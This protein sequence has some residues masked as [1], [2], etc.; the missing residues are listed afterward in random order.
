MSFE[1]DLESFTSKVERL[2]K[3]AFVDATVEVRRSIVEGSTLTGAPGQPV[4]TGALKASF[5]DNFTGPTSWQIT[6]NMEYAP[7]IEDGVGRF[8]PITLR[9]SVGGFHS[10][11]L[12]VAGWQ[13]IVDHVSRGNVTP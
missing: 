6:T 5:V 11:A 7:P 13:R 3:D 12:T 10:V 1:R 4:D 8:G 2:T 9:S